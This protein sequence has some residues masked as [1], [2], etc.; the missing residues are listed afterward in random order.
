MRP[1]RGLRLAV[2]LLL[3]WQAQA[4]TCAGLP[5]VSEVLALD[6]QTRTSRRY[7]EEQVL[8]QFALFAYR[9]LA[10]DIV[11]GRGPYLDTLD[12]GFAAA[13]ADPAEFSAWLRELLR[14]SDSAADFSRRLAVAHAASLAPPAP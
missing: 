4:G 1:L 13:C 10:D 14:A 8:R 12:L 2:L 7:E 6:Q 11:E 9:D 3:P 5:V